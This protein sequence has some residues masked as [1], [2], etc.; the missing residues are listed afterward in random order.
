LTSRRTMSLPDVADVEAGQLLGGQGSDGLEQVELVVTAASSAS[1]G[2]LVESIR[3]LSS[4][5]RQGSAQTSST[6][7]RTPTRTARGPTGARAPTRGPAP[8]PGPSCRRRLRPG[9]AALRPGRRRPA[10][11]GWCVPAPGRPELVAKHRPA[12]VEGHLGADL[13]EHL[14]PGRQPGLD[15]MLGQQPLGEGVEGPDG[16]PVELVE[17]GPAAV[18]VSPS[19]SASAAFSS[20]RRIRSRSSAPAFSVKVMAA[21]ARSSARPVV[22]RARTRSTSALVLPDPA[23]ASTNRVVS[24]SSV[25]RFRAAW[26]GAGVSPCLGGRLP[27]TPGMV[28]V[29]CGAG[30]GAGRGCRPALVPRAAQRPL[31]PRVPLFY[32]PGRHAEDSRVRRGWCGDR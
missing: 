31:A 10:G 2:D 32:R 13:V 28:R 18:P 20:S 11:A 14:D 6:A 29:G 17:G 7:A 21:M 22:T 5:S 25:I 12:P 16:G 24:R 3:S 4:G 15:R 23:P 27:S 8:R 19:G 1:G 26:S 9:P 30:L